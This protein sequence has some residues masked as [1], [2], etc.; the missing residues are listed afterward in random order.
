MELSP[1]SGEPAF[2]SSPVRE[3]SPDWC[4]RGSKPE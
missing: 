2:D 3:L 4:R 1:A